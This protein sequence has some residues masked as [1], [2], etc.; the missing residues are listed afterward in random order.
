MRAQ[1]AVIAKLA[2]RNLRRQVRRS[3]LTAA[4][5][6]AGAALLIF[7]LILGTEPTNNGSTRPC[8][9]PPDTF[10]SSHPDS[11]AVAP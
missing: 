6:I 1:T 4:S 11:T 5:M 7:S 2:L 3:L 10:R 9:W 8:A